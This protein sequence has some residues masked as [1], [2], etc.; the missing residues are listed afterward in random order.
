MAKRI[1]HALTAAA[2]AA[3][4]ACGGAAAWAVEGDGSSRAGSVVSVDEADKAEESS[5]PTSDAV[6]ANDGV[7]VEEVGQKDAEQEDVPTALDAEGN[8]INDG[9]VSDNSFL[10]D[11][12]IA[13]LAGAD[14]Y[15]DGQYVQI[16]GEAVGEAIS[17]VGS[18]DSVWVTLLDTATNSS[19]SV[20]M[21]RADADKIDT[22]GAYGKTGSRVCVKGMYNLACSEHEGESDIHAESVTVEERGF[23]DPDTFDATAF[24]PGVAL[25][26]AG[27]LLMVVF[28]YVRERSR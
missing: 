23:V 3:L 9:Q 7:H 21:S 4:L 8:S 14:S 1:R 26:I 19:V 28:W 27:L 20:V 15:Y 5:E 13:D 11:A 25:V 16:R 18:R 22:F 17:Q 6:S 10:Y 2:L 12:A 24:L